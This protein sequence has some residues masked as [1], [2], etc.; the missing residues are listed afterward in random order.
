[1]SLLKT[2]DMVKI[3]LN[4]RRVDVLLSDV[5][6]AARKAAVKIEI[7]PSQTPW[8]EMFRAH[9]GQLGEGAVL[10]FAVKYQDVGKEIPRHNH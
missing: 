4:A 6:L 3:D 8:Q 9:V 2:N 10:E 7:P 5:E 1:L